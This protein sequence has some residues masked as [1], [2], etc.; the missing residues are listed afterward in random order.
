MYC[1]TGVTS[2]H[3]FYICND[4]LSSNAIEGAWNMI[5][6]EMNDNKSFQCYI[7]QARL[8]IKA[9]DYQNQTSSKVE[10]WQSQ[11]IRIYPQ[12]CHTPIRSFVLWI[13]LTFSLKTILSEEKFILSVNC[14]YRLFLN[15]KKMR[16][17]RMIFDIENFRSCLW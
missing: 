3:N 10:R 11:I 16:K 8:Y 4:F 17:I 9:W 13:W 15:E 14:Q 2:L 6:N 1:S 7:D 12:D 5:V